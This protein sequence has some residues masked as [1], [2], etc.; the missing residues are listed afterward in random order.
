MMNSLTYN[1][2]INQWDNF[3]R[4]IQAIHRDNPT[5]ARIIALPGAVMV[6]ATLFTV[7]TLSLIYNLA[8]TALSLVA[9]VFTLGMYDKARENLLIHS[10]MLAQDAVLIPTAVPLT[11]LL[12]TAAMLA[13]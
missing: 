2:T 5:A 10:F 7:G 6:A 1:M 11:I 3:Q 9:T 13:G 12:F 8:I 4:K